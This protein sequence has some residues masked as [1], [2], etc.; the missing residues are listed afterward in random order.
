MSVIFCAVC[1]DIKNHLTVS[2]L[3]KILKPQLLQVMKLNAFMKL[4]VQ[5]TPAKRSDMNRMADTSKE[6]PGKKLNLGYAAIRQGEK[7]I[8]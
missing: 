4:F 7:I 5:A 6:S 2:L 3:G 8:I 1:W